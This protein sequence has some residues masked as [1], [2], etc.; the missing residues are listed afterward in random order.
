MTL[1]GERDAHAGIQKSELTQAMLERRE[2][3]FSHGEGGRRGQEAHFRAA[4]AGVGADLLQGSDRDAVVEFHE[5]PLAI[6]PD[7]DREPG[8]KRVDDRDA[9]AVQSAGHL[10]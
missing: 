6:A 9:D 10:V 4:L 1:I 7:R 3:E 2:I 5:V 8:R